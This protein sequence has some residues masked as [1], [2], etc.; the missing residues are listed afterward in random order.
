MKWDND[1]VMDIF[2]NLLSGFETL[3]APFTL[4]MCAL[5]G[6]LGTLIGVLPGLGATSAL[7]ILLPLTT[8]MN[9]IDS[10]ILLCGVF[11]GTFYGSSTTSILLNT[12]GQPASVPVTR[13]GYSL[14]RIGKA[15]TALVICGVASFIGGTMAIIVL[16]FFAPALA[17]VAIHVGPPEY[18]AILVAAL[19]L[20]LSLAG[21]SMSKAFIT[22]LVG[23]VIYLIGMDPVSGLPRLTFGFDFLLGGINFIPVLI[24]L[25]AISEILINFTDNRGGVLYQKVGKLYPTWKELRRIVLPATRG[26]LIGTGI[27][28]VPGG[29]AAAAAFVGYEVEQRVAKDKSMFGKGETRGIASSESANNAA[30][31]GAM[32]PL[33][34]LGIP[35]DPAIAVLLGALIIQGATPGPTFFSDHSELAWGII[36]SLY[37]ANVILLILNVPLVGMWASIIKV[38]YPVLASIVLVVCTIGSYAVRNSMI[39]VISMLIFGV[40]GY[41]MRKIEF[42]MEPL[43]LTLILA[44]IINPAFIQS[45]AMSNGDPS[46]FVT[47]PF[48]LLFFVIA[49]ALL[50]FSLRS[51]KRQRLVSQIEEH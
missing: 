47:R 28:V 8:Q 45:L 3:F 40:L 15:G 41:A 24:G 7:A 31:G 35:A 38:P 20:V 6:L 23:F 12:P 30:T 11:M 14:A 16:T 26:G 5:G 42:P 13:D 17:Q 44:P 51:R 33:F 48:A 2:N 10:I 18:F 29:S 27:G 1:D 46:I 25:Y 32:I 34:T 37:V 36:A 22:A 43:V 4:L 39:D 9:A 21:K 49:A 50:F 19:M